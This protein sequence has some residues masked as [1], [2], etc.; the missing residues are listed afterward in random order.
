MNQH[1]VYLTSDTHF[2]SLKMLSN[3]FCSRAERMNIEYDVNWP[4][5]DEKMLSCIK[6][7]DET[8]ID[9]W[10]SVVNEK[11]IVYHLG[12][13]ARVSKIEEMNGILKRLNGK[14]ILVKGNH[15]SLSDSQ[16]S[17]LVKNKTLYDFHSKGLLHTSIDKVKVVLSHYPIL[18]WKG[19][20]NGVPHFFG[21][22]HSG[23]GCYGLDKNLPIQRGSCD[24]GTDAWDFEPVELEK[25]M[26]W[27][28][29]HG[30]VMEKERRG[31]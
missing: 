5:K 8:L 2:S 19:K 30:Q 18:S 24:I 7:H 9:R 26:L 10:N 12:D 4:A 3:D 25:A 27:A 11:D 14:I 28:N 16:Y 22:I 31:I 13:F 20:Y 29:T 6:K 1:K 15:E 23:V 17:S 21:H